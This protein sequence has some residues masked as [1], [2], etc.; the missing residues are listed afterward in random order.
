VQNTDQWAKAGVMIREGTAAGAIEASVVV[1]PG[2]GISFQRRTSTG[3]TS[4][5]TIQGGLAAP[6]WV[7]LTRAGNSFAAYYS[8]T[9]STW[10][11]LGTAQTITMATGATIG[12]AVTSH[13]DGT[14][15]TA[16]FSNVTATP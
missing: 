1:T 13:N 7:R 14:L 10:T 2:N 5:S 12:L 4:V 3:G 6:Y 16:N 9:G 15:C 8:T 11:Q